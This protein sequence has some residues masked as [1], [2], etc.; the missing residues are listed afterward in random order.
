M[1]WVDNLDKTERRLRLEI[2]ILKIHFKSYIRTMNKL[3]E[4]LSKLDTQK[5]DQTDE[6]Q[7]DKD[8]QLLR[9]E[10][11]KDDFKDLAQKAQLEME[12]I[13]CTKRIENNTLIIT[14][15]I[16]GVQ[17]DKDG[18]D[19]P[20][21]WPNINSY[22][23]EDFK[24][25]FE[26]F[27][28]TKNEFCKKEYGLLLLLA[29]KSKYKNNDVA[30]TT[31]ESLF[32]LSKHYLEEI[33]RKIKDENHY[34]LHFINAIQ[35]AFILAK[36]RR[37]SKEEIEK[38]YISLINFIY[39]AIKDWNMTYEWSLTP[40]ADLTNLIL[41][42]YED[43]EHLNNLDL[44]EKVW[45]ASI[46]ISNFY[47]YGG[48]DLAKIGDRFEKKITN[49]N[50]NRWF[51]LIAENFEKLASNSEQKKDI[52]TVTFYEDALKYYKLIE[53][54]VKI[55]E[56]EGKYLNIKNKG[57]GFGTVTSKVSQ[58]ETE[59][60]YNYIIKMVE[61]AKNDD[62]INL[63]I[64]TPMFMKVEELNKL[65]EEHLS[66][67]YIQNYIRKSVVDKRGYTVKEYNT[68]EEKK[69]FTK[70][71]LFG[72]NFQIAANDLW[73]FFLEAMRKKKLNFEIVYDYLS[74]SWVGNTYE[75]MFN[76]RNLS[77]CPLDV[78]IPGLKLAFDE[79][80]KVIEN[81]NYKPNFVCSIDSL[82][83]KIEYLIRF[84]SEE[85]GIPTYKDK[86]TEGNLKE[87]K[88]IDDFIRD[89]KLN[90]NLLEDDIFLINFVLL[91]KV[92]KN[93]RHDVAHGLMDIQDYD[94]LYVILL[95]IIIL[96]LS[97]YRFIKK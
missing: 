46:Y 35:A 53:D 79:F 63:L 19:I 74:S 26:R 40:I 67:P 4:F 47:I 15:K 93:L 69:E 33:R 50:N 28:S 83:L 23:D 42:N 39:S 11:I 31:I 64:S 17:K 14:F 60:M 87:E 85:L 6:F 27:N 44:L 55:K 16:G 30:Q 1:I 25:I 65:T 49:T 80:L 78:I 48:I 56:I 51:K 37:K 62:I 66:K 96:K 68:D 36:S 97:S 18:N 54:D 22:T 70:L 10:L 77:V 90:Q 32:N 95:L 13:N 34:S 58:E 81:Y 20:F 12:V 76:G 5:S 45:E 52:T 2:Y 21:E 72:L 38:L 82:S 43:F 8:L 73:W 3:E 9:D 61:D 29:K 41:T 84:F 57:Y 7:I 75:R 89:K 24:Y 71:E 59:K 91:S 88:N 86:R 92:G 94:P